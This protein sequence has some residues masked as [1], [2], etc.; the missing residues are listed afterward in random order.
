M[1]SDEKTISV[2]KAGSSSP[3]VIA[4]NLALMLAGSLLCALAVNGILIP[5]QFISSGVTGLAMLVY[6]ILPSWDMGLLYFLLNIPLFV[7]GWI[8]V[9]RRFFYYSLVGMLMFTLAVSWIQVPFDV[10]DPLLSALLAGILFGAGAGITLR[11]YGSS[12]GTDILSIILMKRFSIRIGSTVLAFNFLLLAAAGLLFSLESALYTLIFI[13]VSSRIINLVVTGLSQRKAVLIIS[14]QWRKIADGIMNEIKRGVTVIPGEGG[15]SGQEEKILYTVI[16]FQELA[17][18]KQLIRRMD[19]QTFMV[20][21]DTLE[22]MGK[23]IGNQP[24]W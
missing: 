18:L 21:T 5:R 8:Y 20:V 9:S 23:R 15:Y 19:P 14:P 7:L 12:G 11:S 2:E 24:H 22:I 6:F 1:T 3:G 16:T 10:H 17:R 13:F 4:W